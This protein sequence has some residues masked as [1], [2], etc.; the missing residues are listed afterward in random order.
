MTPAVFVDLD[1]PTHPPLRTGRT[2]LVGCVSGSRRRKFAAKPS[3]NIVERV[4][5]VAAFADVQGAQQR[6]RSLHRPAAFGAL[7]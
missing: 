2:S 6:W 3:L 7:I 4:I 1:P 5:G